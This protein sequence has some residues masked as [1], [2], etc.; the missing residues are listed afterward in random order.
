[1]PPFS[2]HIYRTGARKLLRAGAHPDSAQH[3]G[4]QAQV[5]QVVDL[6]I[7]IGFHPKI[8]RHG[9]RSAEC[10]FKTV[11]QI[12]LSEDLGDSGRGTYRKSWVVYSEA[13]DV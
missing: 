7:S 4:H 10:R 11:S 13:L 3:A 5:S 1:M 12:R 2:I 8:L 9:G 6:K